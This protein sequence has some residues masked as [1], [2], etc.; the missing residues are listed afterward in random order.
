V[1]EPKSIQDLPLNG[2]MLIDLALT[3]PDAHVATAP[4]PAT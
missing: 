3:V 4:K 1:V 2:R